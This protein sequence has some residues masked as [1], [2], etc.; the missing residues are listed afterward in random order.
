MPQTENGMK[1]A[2]IIGATSGIGSELAKILVKNEYKV[3]ITGR[4]KTELEK[5]KE[6]D[7]INFN[8]SCFDCTKENNAEELTKLVN[9]IEGL[10]LLILSSGT[11][12]LNEQLDF[13][14]EDSTNKLNVIAFTEIVDWTFN[15]F[16]KQGKGHLVAISSIAGI[17]GS[18]IAPAY[19]ASKDYQIN[20]LEGLRQKAKK[21]KLPIYVTDIRPGFVDTDMAKGEGQF[22]VAT[23]EKAA[24]Q[25]LGL[26]KRKKSVGYVSK[27]WRLISILLKGLPNGIYNR[28]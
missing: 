3:G 1:K 21:T 6:S 4:R 28:M 7:P 12:D 15:Y 17:R 5:L 23:K 2:I 13:N 24:K 10:D 11:G 9:E 25:I 27:R 18:R 8:I 16:E 26:I 20:Y 14:I 19:N 22:W